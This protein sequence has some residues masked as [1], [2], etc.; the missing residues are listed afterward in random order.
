MRRISLV[1]IQSKRLIPLPHGADR[2]NGI[3]LWRLAA[4]PRKTALVVSVSCGSSSPP[5]R[6]E[7]FNEPN[8]KQDQAGMHTTNTST[9]T[10]ELRKG[11]RYRL[12]AL[13]QFLWASQHG[14]TYSG[15]GVTR[16]INASGVYVL[17]KVFPPVGSRV[18]MEISL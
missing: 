9:Q 3:F 4:Q 13:V 6:L 17:A 2:R 12:N 1:I 18:Q 5:R 8:R 15:K 10:I 16:D 14:T 7:L 11:N